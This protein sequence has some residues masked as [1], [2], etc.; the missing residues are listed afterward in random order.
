MDQ[1]HKTSKTFRIDALVMET[2]EQEADQQEVSLNVLVNKVLTRYCDWDRYETKI[3]MMPV[4][5]S[6]LTS[7]VDTAA[8]IAKENGMKDAVPFQDQMIKTAAATA[9]SIMK[10]KVIFMRGSYDLWTLLSVLQDYMKASGSNSDHRVEPGGR[11]VF[12]IQHDLGESWSKFTKELMAAIFENL[13][14]TG[15][16]I[17]TTPNTVVAEVILR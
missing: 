10:D 7:L 8:N 5:K 16:E 2:L 1:T 15:A 3:G 6:I 12:M 11:H 9:I 4:P 14:R 13:A 17:S